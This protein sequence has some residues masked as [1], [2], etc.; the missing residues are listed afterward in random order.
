[1]TSLKI[2]LSLAAAAVTGP[3]W[4]Q[5]LSLASPALALLLQLLGIVL[6]LLQILKL[7]KDWKKP[8]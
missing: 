4:F 5:V 3:A 7:L 1:M 8:K 2:N 6:V